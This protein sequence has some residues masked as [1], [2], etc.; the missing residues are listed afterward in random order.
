[1]SP[2]VRIKLGIEGLLALLGQRLSVLT[3][4]RLNA[5]IN[6]L[7]VGRWMRARGFRSWRHFWT[8][9]ELYD[10]V[11][12]E[13]ADEK[14]LYLEFGVWRGAS[15][16]RWSKLLRHPETRLHGFDSFEGL[17]TDWHAR[18][19][20]KAAFQPPA[21]FQSRVIRGSASTKAGSTRRCRP[22]ASLRTIGWLQTSTPT[23]TRPRSTSSVSYGSGSRSEHTSFSTNFRTE[24]MSFERSMN[25]ST[26]QECGSNPPARRSTSVA[27]PLYVANK[28][29]VFDRMFPSACWRGVQRP[30]ADSRRS[31]STTTM[32][33]PAS[34]PAA[35]QRRRGCCS[36]PAGTLRVRSDLSPT[37]VP[38]DVRRQHTRSEQ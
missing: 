33:G 20:R 35:P 32:T 10:A 31:A 12:G 2:R 38:A 4:H 24:S 11:A 28:P 30:L 7:E 18:A 1:M 9:E 14:V 29:V 34:R 23:F 5:V 19:R 22:L 6:Y 3:I 13:I 8:R 27:L 37:A 15:I 36:A 17:P 16:S 25:S 26:K 21:R